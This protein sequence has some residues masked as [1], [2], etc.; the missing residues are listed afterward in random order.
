MPKLRI[1]FSDFFNVSPEKIKEYGAFNISLINDL[2][3]FIDPFLLF[4]NEKYIDLHQ[5]IIKYVSFLRDRSQNGEL[6]RGLIKSWFLFPE[7]KQNWLGYSMVGNGGSGLGIDFANSLIT[8]FSSIL[9]N[10]GK[11][12]ITEGSHLEK[13]CL[14]KEGVGKDSISDF[15]TNL[16]KSFLLKYTEDF[17]KENI[18]SKY[19]SE[20]LVPKVEFNY[21]TRSWMS[22]KFTL[23]TY[24]GDYVL[25]TP[26]DILTK[27]ETWINRN[28]M[29]EDFRDICES[30]PNDQ[31][32]GQLSDYFNRCLPDSPKKKERESA[33]D[34]TIKNYPS[35]IDYY[36]R[37]KEQ[38]SG[39]AK[40]D[41]NAKVSET[42]QRYIEAVQLLVDTIFNK[43][44]EF[45]SSKDDTFE[46]AY[47]RV[48]YL[49]QVIE[50][51]DG[52]KVFYLN[53]VPIKR[54]ADLQLMFRLTW[55]ASISDVNS[56]VNNGRAPVDYKISRG[57]KDKT[58]VEFKLASNSKLKQNL[59]NQVKVYE[60]ANET[61]KSI[62][63]IL[64]F[65]DRELSGLFK[66]FKE[67][68]I[69][70]GKDLVL[71]DARPNKVSASNVK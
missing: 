70:E 27:D 60:A 40:R 9:K 41:S 48:C 21:E 56:E 58:L 13:L 39:G 26:R 20:H 68:G 36:I 33:A 2:P 42:E 35:F 63:V 29:I 64:Y 67:L 50:N 8:S 22:K 28:E 47:K 43:H 34:L 5:G 71:I 25:L 10:F 19:L 53:G 24:A 12:E 62:K 66:T 7:V 17:S 69:K 37:Y 11:E 30:I 65:T 57:S 61:K 44:Q 4:N 23:P 14:I 54:E 38:N 6:N 31:L 18:D 49:K 52:Y 16:I 55:F 51:N 46:E 1:Y 32:R 15:T 3:L 45:F 59:A